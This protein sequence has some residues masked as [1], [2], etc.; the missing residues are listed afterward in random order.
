MRKLLTLLPGVCLALISLTAKADPTLTFNSVPG[1]G[2]S[3]R[4]VL[5]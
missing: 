2:I 3:A 4:T 5:R 1:G